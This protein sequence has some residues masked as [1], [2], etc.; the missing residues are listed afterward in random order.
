MKIIEKLE[1]HLP[2]IIS[3]SRFD[4]MYR[5][6]NMSVLWALKNYDGKVGWR[7]HGG[8]EHVVVWAET[9]EGEVSWHVPRKKVM[10]CAWLE[11]KEK[12]YE[13]YSTEEKID[14]VENIVN[15]EVRIEPDEEKPQFE[16]D[17]EEEEE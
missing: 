5:D 8:G 4:Q 9:D 16:E 7:E 10:D 15:E 13:Y 17:L 3:K 2:K 1:K 14:K 12:M 11:Q 6:R